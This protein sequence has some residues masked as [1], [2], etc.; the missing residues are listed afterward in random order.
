MGF[1]NVIALFSIKRVERLVQK[2]GKCTQ[3]QRPRRNLLRSI[4]AV[5]DKNA[6]IDVMRV[7]NQYGLDVNVDLKL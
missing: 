7:E 1:L 3:I 4:S 2:Y 6:R 5:I